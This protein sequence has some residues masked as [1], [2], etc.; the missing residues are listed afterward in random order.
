MTDLRKINT[1][2]T[3]HIIKVRLLKINEHEKELR[4]SIYNEIKQEIS[5][6]LDCKFYNLS[7]LLIWLVTY[8]N[9]MINNYKQIKDIDYLI[10]AYMIT[11]T[12]QEIL[13]LEL[14]YIKEEV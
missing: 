13:T 2:I 3:N 6:H 9:L 8:R 1:V 5:T 10:K 7:N 4:L 11:E 12:L 14:Q